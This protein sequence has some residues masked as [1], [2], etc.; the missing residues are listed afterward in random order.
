MGIT[1]H[2]QTISAAIKNLLKSSAAYFAKLFD[3]CKYLGKKCKPRSD[4][5]QNAAQTFRSFSR[6]QKLTLF[7]VE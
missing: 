2:Q 7:I 3:V 6:R 5:C 4:L 1:G